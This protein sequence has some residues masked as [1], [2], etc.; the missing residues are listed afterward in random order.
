MVLW[1]RGR[2]TACLMVLINT[3]SPRVRI[4]SNEKTNSRPR[5]P[6]FQS[7]QPPSNT[8]PGKK[9]GLALKIG[10]TQSSRGLLNVWFT[11]RNRVTSSDWSQ[12]IGE[13]IGCPRGE[14]QAEF[15]WDPTGGASAPGDRLDFERTEM[16]AAG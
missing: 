8:S 12:G 14:C 5:A 16:G 6:P 2:A 1:G 3:M 11:K 9:N 15:V 4:T 10:I 7:S 13:I